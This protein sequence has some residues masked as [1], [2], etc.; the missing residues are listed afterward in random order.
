MENEENQAN[1]PV[2]SYGKITIFESHE[3]M[4][5]DTRLGMAMMTPEKR[6]AVLDKMRKIF[7]RMHFGN[8]YDEEKFERVITFRE[9]YAV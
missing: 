9:P 3:A 4:E 5:E 6:L 8:K 7:R 2:A 1:E